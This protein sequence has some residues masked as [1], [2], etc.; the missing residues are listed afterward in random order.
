MIVATALLVLSVLIGAGWLRRTQPNRAVSGDPTGVRRQTVPNATANGREGNKALAGSSHTQEG[1]RS[2]DSGEEGVPSQPGLQVRFLDR[3][4]AGR[5]ETPRVLV[6]SAP[7]HFAVVVAHE[8]DATSLRVRVLDG[9]RRVDNR[10]DARRVEHVSDTHSGTDRVLYELRGLNRLQ[11]RPGHLHRGSIEVKTGE[12]RVRQR[13]RVVFPIQDHWVSFGFDFGRQEWRVNASA[14]LHR[15][16]GIRS[17]SIR[18]FR[19][20]NEL[21]VEFD[22]VRVGGRPLD[23]LIGVRKR[24][25]EKMLWATA[26]AS[27]GWEK[28]DLVAVFDLETVSGQKSTAIWRATDRDG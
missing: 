10:L 12:Y 16:P 18:L 13:Y 27:R 14:T 7:P 2:E 4:L 23:E 15:I 22:E 17:L 20:E 24:I 6:S 5:S 9:H 28:R 3:V 25:E 26:T 8:L 11:N 21:P 1:M 19:G